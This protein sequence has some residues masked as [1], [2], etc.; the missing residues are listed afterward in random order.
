MGAELALSWGREL[1]SNYACVCIF[2]P[3]CLLVC[4]LGF[5][6]Q[7]FPVSFPFCFSHF[8]FFWCKMAWQCGRENAE[9]LLILFFGGA[10]EVFHS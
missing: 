6:I 8:S 1:N 5:Y 10:L 3:I 9:K 7:T 4:H 2:P